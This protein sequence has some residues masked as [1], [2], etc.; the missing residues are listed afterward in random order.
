MAAAH[1]TSSPSSIIMAA[2][3]QLNNNNGNNVQACND[4]KCFVFVFFTTVHNFKLRNLVD[5]NPTV[6]AQLLGFSLHYTKSSFDTF[7]E[8]KENM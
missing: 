7:S 6:R 1:D 2:W 8:S 5:E 3:A 4:G